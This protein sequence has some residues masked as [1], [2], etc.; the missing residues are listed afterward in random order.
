MSLRRPRS[1]TIGISN[2]DFRSKKDEQNLRIFEPW[3]VP[4]DLG[5]MGY[6]NYQN[7][8]KIRKELFSPTE[9]INTYKDIV[10]DYPDPRFYTTAKF[11]KDNNMNVKTRSFLNTERAS[12]LEEII[13]GKEP[14]IGDGMGISDTV[15]KRKGKKD[16][17]LQIEVDY[18][19]LDEQKRQI[20]KT[21]NLANEKKKINKNA[22]LETQITK[23]D[24]KVTDNNL[25]NMNKIIELRQALRRRYG[26]RKKPNKIFQQWAK[27]FPNKITVY[28]AYKMINSL[29]IPINYNET[30]ALIASG[31]NQG[32]EF[33]N[34]EEFSNL[35]FNKN[36]D[37]YEIP[38]IEHAKINNILSEKEQNNLNNKIKDNNKE[39]NDKVN[40]NILKDYLSQRTITFIKNLKEISRDKYL[41]TNIENNDKINMTKNNNK[42]NY[43]KF[44]QA[45]LSLNP[46]E[47]F[48]K[49]KYIKL[50]FNE[51]KDKNDL[52]DIKN[53]DNIL[54]ENNSKE[55]MTKLKDNLSNKFKDEI[56]EKKNSL[57][58]YVLENKNKKLLIYQKKYDLDNQLLIKK[59]NELKQKIENEKITTEINSTVPS[60]PWIHHIYD[61]RSEHFNILNRV[62]HSFSA[63]PSIKQNSLKGNT[64]FGSNP[65]WRN[66]SEIL[67]GD[68]FSSTYINEKDRFNL[69]RDVAKDDKIKNEKI[70]KG[71][72]YRIKTSIQKFEENNYIKQFLK[73]EKDKYSQLEKS[74]RKYNY[75]ELFKKNNFFIE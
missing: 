9:R 62:E 41:F 33:L 23:I 45:V 42:C 72:E 17:K 43:D 56:E 73:E 57:K 26:N 20:N 5:T 7:P 46:P 68:K 53:F 10:N 50:L 48:S 8:R 54:F 2:I 69:N 29:N 14:F 65:I 71:R 40:L 34:V 4:K 31:S 15:R 52:I 55:Y 19:L 25:V 37:S 44:L 58:N 38:L 63:K 28:D 12:N 59:D 1:H 75:E 32:N 70:K 30:R 60:T 39:I 49:E 61:K 51:Y 16:R 66:T 67:I 18:N 21:E 3:Q 6:K 64:R 22:I 36:E 74:K 35:I 11:Y 47:L 27:T 13:K 24:T